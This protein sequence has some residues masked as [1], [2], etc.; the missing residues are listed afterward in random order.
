M[1]KQLE[2]YCNDTLVSDLS[3]ATYPYKAY[4]ET[5][6]SYGSEA[7]NTHLKSAGFSKD[8]SGQEG[9]TAAGAKDQTSGYY[10]RQLLVKEGKKNLLQLH[11]C[12]Q[13]C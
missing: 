5:L 10:H 1:Y 12:M 8:F 6:L 2:V 7:K 4:F 11:N 3:S 13:I 9:K